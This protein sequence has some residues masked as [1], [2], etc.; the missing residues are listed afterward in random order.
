MIG[1]KLKSY[2]DEGDAQIVLESAQDKIKKQM[3][4]NLKQMVPMEDPKTICFRN[5]KS[6]DD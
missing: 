5:M 3:R 1:E 2:E 6:V 4:E